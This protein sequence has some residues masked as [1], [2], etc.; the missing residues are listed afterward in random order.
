MVGRPVLVRLIGVRV[1]IPQ[2]KIIMHLCV[3]VGALLFFNGKNTGEKAARSRAVS[4]YVILFWHYKS[5]R[6][7]RRGGGVERKI[8]EQF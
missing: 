3:S 6:E 8:A 7:V 2:Q 4:G 5:I 1:P